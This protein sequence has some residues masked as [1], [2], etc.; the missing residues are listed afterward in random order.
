MS[1]IDSYLFR[2]R[3]EV[4]ANFAFLLSVYSTFGDELPSHSLQKDSA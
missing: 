3:S 1:F 4:I 2:G